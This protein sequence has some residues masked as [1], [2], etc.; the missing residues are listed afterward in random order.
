MFKYR[1]HLVNRMKIKKSIEEIFRKILLK[2][3]HFHRVKKDTLV[4]IK[5]GQYLL[6]GKR[7]EKILCTKWYYLYSPIFIF[8]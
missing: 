4:Y 2:M 6:P 8:H 5:R 7:T 1:C 3:D